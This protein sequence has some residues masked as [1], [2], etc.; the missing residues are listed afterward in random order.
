MKEC[1]VLIHL[2]YEFPTYEFLKINFNTKISKCP[3]QLGFE[4]KINISETNRTI[5]LEF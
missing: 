3:M 4:V 5:E 2:I 1:K